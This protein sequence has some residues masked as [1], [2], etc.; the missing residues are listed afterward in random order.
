MKP[1]GTASV[2]TVGRGPRG[3][4]LEEMGGHRRPFRGDREAGRA[5][6]KEEEAQSGCQGDARSNTTVREGYHRAEESG[7]CQLWGPRGNGPTSLS[8]RWAPIK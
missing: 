4:A 2:R 8:L 6:G 3:G 7:C 5:G 1:Q